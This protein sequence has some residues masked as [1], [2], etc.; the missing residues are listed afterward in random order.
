MSF[1]KKIFA[2]KEKPI[3]SYRDFWDWFQRN[4]KSFFKVVKS[5]GDIEKK[6]FKK[7]SPK[8]GELKDGY[9][10]L[11]GMYDDH[12]VELIF[13]ADG[14][15]KNIVF[16]E[17]IVAHAPKIHG[18]KFTALKP[19]LG[20]E[21]VNIHMAGYE[22]SSEKI[23]FYSND[24]SDYPDEIDITL[25]HCDLTEENSRQINIGTALFLDNY[26]GELAFVNNID[27][28]R[29]IGKDEA[30]KE[31]VPIAK[32]KD[33]VNWRQKEFIEKYEEVYYET[34]DD[35]YSI[36]EATSK[37]GNRLIA[38]I[39]TSLLNWEG[40]ASHPWIAEITFHFD[41][42]EKNGMPHKKDYQQL[43][44][45]EDVLKERLSSNNGCLYLGRETCPNERHVFFVCKDFRLPSKVF[46]D[47]QQDNNRLK[48][49]YDIYKDKYWQ[50][51]EN[52]RPK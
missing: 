49:T 6:F 3:K 10:F 38:V 48:P 24:H 40:K 46:F 44:E 4:E 29:V 42:Q 8:L 21:N 30:E 31:L 52:F 1:F 18:W 41:G 28:Y 34:D 26:L 27:Q 32:L 14:N 16:M 12:T 50:S 13:T 25:I 35:E 33:F 47:I 36:L 39:N 2:P 37:N 22:F 9:F 45:V 19:A 7:L 11:T 23:F 43:D 15:I 5:S 17:E 51:F 20:I